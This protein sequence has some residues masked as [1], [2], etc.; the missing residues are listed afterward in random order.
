MN[1]EISDFLERDTNEKMKEGLARE[2]AERLARVEMQGVQQTKERVRELRPGVW[3]E[4][5]WQDIGFAAR[6]LRKRPA[7]VALAVATMALSIGATTAIFSLLHAVLLHPLPYGDSGRL[8]LFQTVM[9]DSHVAQVS[10]LDFIDLRDQHPDIES[11]TLL[12]NDEFVLQEQTSGGISQPMRKLGLQVMPNFFQTLGVQ[13]SFGRGFAQNERV[14]GKNQVAV[15]SN[16]LWK[17]A[18]GGQH[19]IIGKEMLLNERPF[20]IIGVMPPDFDVFLPMTDS[21]TIQDTDI[22]IPLP[23]GHP[24]TVHRSTFTFESIARLQKNVNFK[25]AEAET[26]QISRQLAQKN[27]DTNTNRFLI[28]TPLREYV[29]GG[30]LPALHLLIAALVAI[31]LVACSNLSNLM[32][33]RITERDQELTIRAALGAPSSRLIRQLILESILVVGIGGLGGVFIA[34]FLLP[35]MTERLASHVPDA[36]SIGINAPVMSFTIL[37]CLITGIASALIPARALWRRDGTTNLNEGSRASAG[38]QRARMRKALVVTEL[39]LSCVLLAGAILLGSSFLSLMRVRLGFDSTKLL[40]F[41]ITLSDT[42]YE[43]RKQIARTLSEFTQ[44]IAALPGVERAT[45]TGSLPLSG[46]NTSTSVW[47]EGRLPPSGI[48]P[49]EVRWQFV[50]PNYFE[51]MRIPLVRGRF[52]EERDLERK[53]HVTLISESEAQRDF[54][55]EN[56]IGKRVSY[57]PPG[58]DTDWHEII[59]VVGDIRH[60]TLREEPTPRVYDLLGQHAGLSVYIAIRTGLSPPRIM[61]SIRAIASQLDPGAPLYDVR[62]MEQWKTRA[63]DR[64]QMLVTILGFFAA[65]ALF[66]GAVGAYGVISSLVTQRAREIGVRMVLGAEPKTILISTILEGLKLAS[67]GL[68]IGLLAFFALAPMLRGMLFGVQYSNPGTIAT[69]ITVLLFVSLIAAYVPAQRA[70]RVPPIIVLRQG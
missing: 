65:A 26:L 63:A 25:K 68:T 55:N 10:Y 22:Y 41:E 66:L 54:P 14:P 24:Y 1:E 18:F 15:I 17:E 38:I 27:P 45:A 5:F 34:W 58:Q 16:R 30:A 52:L 28:M 36:T 19:N 6:I 4:I 7:Y 64:E 62:T 20:L 9:P 42:R 59:G 44:R 8:V 60:G 57:G 51:T 47:I 69:V 12:L 11:A 37:V 43:T 70:S 67:A 29:L 21:F 48:Q 61:P 13:P 56:P 53:S 49:P 32:I 3:F 2:S 31:L 50:Q 23:E 33:G 35:Q 46:N 40:T 39:A